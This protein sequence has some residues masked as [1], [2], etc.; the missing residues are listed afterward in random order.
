MEK[1]DSLLRRACSLDPKKEGR[2]L[3]P[4]VDQIRACLIPNPF[5]GPIGRMGVER[6]N[7]II[8]LFH[9]FVDIR[10]KSEERPT[11]EHTYRVIEALLTGSVGAICKFQESKDFRDLDEALAL[12]DEAAYLCKEYLKSRIYHVACYIC[13]I[14]VY[15]KDVIKQW[16]HLNRMLDTIIWLAGDDRDSQKLLGPVNRRK[17]ECLLAMNRHDTDEFETAIM[18]ASN[19]EK[20]LYALVCLHPP[21]SPFV[22]SRYLKMEKPPQEFGGYFALHGDFGT[23]Q[24]FPAYQNF[25]P[26][27][28]IPTETRLVKDKVL[29]ERIKTLDERFNSNNNTNFLE[30]ANECT[31]ILKAFPREKLGPNDMLGVFFLHYWITYSYI[32]VGKPDCGLYYAKQIRKIFQKYPFTVGFGLFL[33]LKCKVQMGDVHRLR[34]PPELASECVITWDSIMQLHSAINCV[35]MNDESCFAAFEE[36][37]HSNNIIVKREAVNY[38]VVACRAFDISPPL[39]EFEHLCNNSREY[40]AMWVYNYA[41]ECAMKMD[42]DRYWDQKAPIKSSELVDRL[43]KVASLAAGYTSIVRKVRQLQALICGTTNVQRTARYITTSLSTSFDQFLSGNNDSM[44]KLPFP[45]LSIM[46]FSVTGLEPCLLMAMYRAGSTPVVLRIET[47]DMIDDFI[48]HL[49]QIHKES[50]EIPKDIPKD[51]WWKSKL[52]LNER[53]KELL[54]DFEDRVLGVWK[55]ILTPLVFNPDHGAFESALLASI[56]AYDEKQA[57]VKTK[58]EALTGLRLNC[59][60]KLAGNLALGLLLGKKIHKIPWE[61]LPCVQKYGISIMRIP[62]LQLIELYSVKKGPSK[63][64]LIVNPRSGFYVLNPDGSLRDTQEKF[65]PFFSALK[66]DGISGKAPEERR[67]E[68]AIKK[69]DLFVYCGHG[70]GNAFYDYYK[71][72]EEKKPC[73]ATMLLIGCSSGALA[74]DGET[75]PT[76][77]PYYCLASGS[78]AVVGNLW[79]V[80]DREI[81][82]FLDSLLENTVKDEERKKKKDG[83]KNRL[84]EAVNIARRNCKLRWL[85][86]AAPVVY[87]FPTEFVNHIL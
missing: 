24:S 54:Y 49:A 26:N 31:Q 56:Y 86:G 41:V 80:T 28:R 6:I 3:D 48:D 25:W 29:M 83:S 51:K 38:Y 64:P 58:L 27:L 5:P 72:L 15:M 36:I 17:A 59:R 62:S 55:G 1:F 74:D 44:D 30:C 63:G 33:E 2:K 46:Y 69:R 45:L 18:K 10:F 84:A 82:R 12:V 70:N 32:A 7:M 79:N 13:N 67:I 81:N 53:L 8:D 19:P 78:G 4:L 40:M 66:W 23:L 75:D 61:N 16:D 34:Y 39:Y 11:P 60:A 50:S 68:A 22:I 85:T 87:G 21:K 43:S 65:Q 76:G 71:M 9:K 57:A 37:F 47:G 42:L 77:V 14:S 35:M 52:A 20:V 73:N